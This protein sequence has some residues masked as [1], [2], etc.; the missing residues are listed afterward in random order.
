MESV[1][2]SRED[3]ELR[4]LGKGRIDCAEISWRFQ[5]LPAS[6]LEEMA[7]E[8]MNVINISEHIWLEGHL[9]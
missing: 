5:G 2:S 3:V 9:K 8:E 7:L 1:E 6:F 4:C